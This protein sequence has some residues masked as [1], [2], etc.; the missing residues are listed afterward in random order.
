MIFL[1]TSLTGTFFTYTSEDIA[2]TTAYISDFFSDTK[3]LL[4]VII[5]LG[6]GFW[7]LD[8]IIWI[9]NSLYWRKK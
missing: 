4:F 3:P 7:I 9:T 5:G 1:P 6:L 2:S 8:A